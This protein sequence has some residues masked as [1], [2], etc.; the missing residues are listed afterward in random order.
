MCWTSKHK[1]D[2]RSAASGGLP[3]TRAVRASPNSARLFAPSLRNSPSVAKIRLEGHDSLHPNFSL[4]R[5][6]DARGAPVG[7]GGTSSAHNDGAR[8][9]SYLSVPSS[10]AVR[11]RMVR[12]SIAVTGPKLDEL[13][14][15]CEERCSDD[16]ADDDI[17]GE[18]GD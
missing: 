6:S 12:G 14:G 8:A 1:Q 9:P 16:H 3:A 7:G 13:G 18:R 11:F 4:A 17:V 10:S 15:Y 5:S 2:N